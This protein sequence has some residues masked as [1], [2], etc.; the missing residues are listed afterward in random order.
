MTALQFTPQG[1]DRLLDGGEEV[2]ETSREPV[3]VLCG[4]TG[5]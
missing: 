2:E 4:P 5:V 1:A 3:S